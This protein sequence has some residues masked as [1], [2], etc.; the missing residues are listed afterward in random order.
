MSTAAAFKRFR[1]EAKK[2]AKNRAKK[3]K[4][5]ATITEAANLIKQLLHLRLLDVR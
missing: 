3:R 1:R 4:N 2:L 5:S